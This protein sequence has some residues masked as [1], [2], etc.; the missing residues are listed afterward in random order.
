LAKAWSAGRDEAP[1]P[2]QWT[3]PAFE[4]TPRQDES[5][6]QISLTGDSQMYAVSNTVVSLRM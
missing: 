2:N 1:H 6:R 3:A 4:D 5:Q